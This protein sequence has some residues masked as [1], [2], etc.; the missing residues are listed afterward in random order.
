MLSQL[1]DVASLVWFDYVD[2]KDAAFQKAGLNLDRSS[3]FAAFCRISLIT[4]STARMWV[5]CR[6]CRERGSIGFV[7]VWRIILRS[8]L[9]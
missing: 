7:P 8:S 1:Q 2:Q 5:W 4:H 9:G 6:Q 3:D